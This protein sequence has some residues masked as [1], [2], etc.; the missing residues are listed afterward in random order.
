MAS[1]RD[2][3]FAGAIAEP[4]AVD[5]LRRVIARAPQRETRGVADWAQPAEYREKPRG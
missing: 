4:Y 3:G 5:E 1:Y 2:D